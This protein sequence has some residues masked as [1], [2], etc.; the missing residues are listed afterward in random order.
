MNVWII[1]VGE[2]LPIDT[3][4]RL[5]RNGLLAEYLT[6][7]GHKVTWWTS[8]YEHGQKK[9]RFEKDTILPIFE[10]NNKI[11]LLKA[12]TTYKKNVSLKRI[13]FNRQT[14][15][16]F[17]RMASKYEKPDIIFCSYPPI[18]LAHAA[19][20]YGKKNKVPV[21]VDV[22]DLWPDIFK[23]A[24]PQ[25]LKFLSFFVDIIFGR[26][27]KKTFSDAYAITGIV[28]FHLRWG[29]NK[30]KRTA[31]D[32]DRY[33][34]ISYKQIKL[35]PTELFTELKKWQ[36]MGITK[37]TWNICF[38][39]TMS[40][41]SMDMETLIK[42]FEKLNAKYPLTR[43]VLCGAGDGLEK[44]KDIANNNPNI[45]FPGWVNKNQIQ[46]LM[47]ISKIGMY[48]LKNLIDFKDSLTNK[49]TEYMSAGLPVV[50]SL[51]GYSKKYIEK[52][53]VG[54]TYDE[55]CI[56]SCYDKLLYCYEN[57]EELES[58]AKN[59]TERHKID[60]DSNVVNENIEKY[61]GEIVSSYNK[62]G[63]K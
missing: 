59:A 11:I 40:D 14:A 45:I 20:K 29:I 36:E 1:Q 57:P 52:Y 38:F 10:S 7:K 53:S 4:P 15:Q 32:R 28:P 33:F 5:M 55:G 27:V 34:Y 19:V 39:G 26:M 48:P 18:E 63:L 31:T 35:T 13:I 16:K 12:K 30:A 62:Y 49:M 54:L 50:S 21:I 3:K 60:F 41:L 8:T 46:S 61:L 51:S 9:E 2:P 24:F 58:L 23:R 47:A 6:S 56:D 44:F 42:A 17:T 37:N 25:K 22:L 43:L